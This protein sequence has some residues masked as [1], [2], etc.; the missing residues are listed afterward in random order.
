VFFLALFVYPVLLGALSLGLGLLVERASAVRLPGPLLPPLGFAA[1]IGLTQLGTQLTATARLTAPVVVVLALAGLWLGRT[2]LP[3]LRTRGALV[4]ALVAVATFTSFAA[5]VLFSGHVGWTSYGVD[6]TPPIH[7]LGADQLA[8]HGRDFGNTAR[9]SSANITAG[10]FNASYPSGGN[11]ALGVTQQLT[12]VSVPWLFQPFLAFSCAMLGL[13]LFW[14]IRQVLPS[15]WLAALTAF[16]AAQPA[17][18][19]AFFLQ[20]QMKEVLAA[21]LV[22]LVAATVVVYGR[23]LTAGPRAA[24]PLAVAG[25]AG[26]GATGVGFGAWLGPGALL[27][28]IVA[29]RTFWR[30]DRKQ[31]LAH[32]AVFVVAVVVL[33]VPA[34]A[35]MRV[36]FQSVS[37]LISQEVPLGS[38]LTPLSTLHTAGIWWSEDYRV[39]P[40]HNLGI[41]FAAIGAVGFG[42]LLSTEWA[43]RR[44]HWPLL[45]FAIVTVPGALLLARQ[46]TPWIDVKAMILAAPLVLTL[47]LLGG[48]GALRDTP[49]RFAG[50]ALSGVIAL[51][52]LYSTALMYHGTQMSPSARYQELERIAERFSGQGPTLRPDFDDYALF[53]ARQMDPVSTGDPRPAV[54]VELANGQ[55]PGYG[56]SVRLD[57]IQASFVEKYPLLVLQRS[58]FESRPPANYQ[59]AYSGRYY[60]VWR[61]GPG[62]V[63]A[64]VGVGSTWDATA[65]VS[66]TDVRRLA[67][68]ARSTGATLA[69]AEGPAVETVPVTN[70]PVPRGWTV[71]PNDPAVFGTVGQGTLKTSLSVPSSGMY[72]LWLGGT[73]TRAV[74]VSVDGRPVGTLKNDIKYSG[75]AQSVGDVRLS[76]GPHQLTIARGGGSLAPGNGA[77]GGIGPAALT[78]GTRLERPVR[79]LDPDDY[80]QACKRPVD[81]VEVVRGVPLS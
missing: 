43:I 38:L 21:L 16:I 19:Y 56:L 4:A 66:C 20:G 39:G 64:H 81:W 55:L 75:L 42:I 53:F 51:G 47:G 2:R 58:P 32:A 23:T 52:V 41:N 11:S 3:A 54:T 31:V 24:I 30:S 59:L 70:L 14:I 8:N 78:A 13:V 36:Y 37:N 45:V 35:G 17:L 44:R 79:R 26:M 7:W 12:G 69:V 28:V 48:L 27:A 40:T 77:G 1:L 6:T 10:Y 61:R 57:Q 74:D 25:A 46:G 80:R 5:P 63:L 71:L 9:S 34:V 22:P 49:A 67:R 50:Y 72:Q 62:T 68:Q 76:A 73:F 18:L 33:A 60:E 29:I 15:R 65:P